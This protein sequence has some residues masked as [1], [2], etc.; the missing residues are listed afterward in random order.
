MKLK[1]AI[2][3]AIAMTTSTTVYAGKL[4]TGDEIRELFSNKT[5]DIENVK[6]LHQDQKHLQAYTAADGS[7]LLYIPWKNKTSES[8]WWV[9][10]DKYCVSSPKKGDYCKEIM[11]AGNGVYHG[12]DNGRQVRTFSNFRDGNQL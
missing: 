12:L 11:D 7:R 3:I 1:S 8:K 5:C 9:D 10:G 2:L 6:V 4:L